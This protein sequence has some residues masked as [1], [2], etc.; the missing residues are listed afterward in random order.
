MNAIYE[1]DT[2]NP[3][4]RSTILDEDNQKVAAFRAPHRFVAYDISL[5]DHSM[6]PD[7][8]GG[9]QPERVHALYKAAFDWLGQ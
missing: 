2:L 8:Y 1:R 4:T 9:D 5:G 7:L 6:T 3:T